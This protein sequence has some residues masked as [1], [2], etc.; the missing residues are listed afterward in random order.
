MPPD[1]TRDAFASSPQGAA[2][3][4]RLAGVRLRYLAIGPL[5]AL[6]I[7]FGAI[8]TN[9]LGAADRLDVLWMRVSSALHLTP[10]RPTL[11]TIVVTPRPTVSPTPEATPEPT[12]RASREATPPR[13]RG[14][15]QDPRRGLHI[16][17]DR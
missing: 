3:P 4:R 1:L 8:W 2:V 5:L 17:A 16:G 11:E 13:G 10:D 15:G 9:T 14:G 12:G 6:L 7:G